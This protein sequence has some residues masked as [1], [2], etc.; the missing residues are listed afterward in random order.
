MSSAL[1]L[2][3]IIMLILLAMSAFF[4]G[5]ETALTTVSQIKMKTMAKEGDGRAKR[6]LAVLEKK[7]KMLS[8]ILIGNNIVNL[9][10]SSLA[11]T[12]ATKLLGSVGA[13]IA[14]GILTF[15]I[16]IFGEITPKNRAQANNVNLSLRYAGI[17]WYLMTI[18]TP[19]IFV[20]N[21]ISGAILRLID[22]NNS[23][24]DQK[25]TEEELR[26]IV[27]ESKE[28]GVIL[29]NEQKYIHNLFD[30]S[31]A[32]AKEVMI[33]RIDVTMVNVNWSYDKLMD[34]IREEMLTRMPVYEGDK[35]HIIGIINVKDLLLKKEGDFHIRDYLRDAYFTYEMKNTLELFQ[36]MRKNSISMAIVLDEYG[37]VAGLITMEDLLEELVGE[38]RDE[39]D[40]DEEDDIV[41]LSD[42]EFL[43]QA[44]MNLEDLCKVLPLNFES[45]DYDTLGGYLTGLFDHVPEVGETYVTKEG[46]LLRVVATGHQRIEKVRIRFPKAVKIE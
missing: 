23:G 19:L 35:D 4:S 11:T 28:E 44:S 2:R 18:L 29:T 22:G 16:L 3:F 46:I 31:D 38:I 21:H 40:S 5:S 25:M 37:A 45:D 9:S 20:I 8:A 32:T 12:I 17:I 15:L 42:R 1:I 24:D 34:L 43:V 33:P 27:D 6:V 26:T 10:A 7:D 30:F 36:E 39:Y 14:T 41:V 13:G